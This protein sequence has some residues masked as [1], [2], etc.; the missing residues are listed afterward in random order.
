LLY[1]GPNT[2]LD[3]EIAR[4]KALMGKPEAAISLLKQRRELSPVA[5][6]RVHSALG[7][8]DGALAR[9]EEAC[10]GRDW[11]ISDLKQDCRLDGLRSDLRFRSL[12]AT[13]GI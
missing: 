7:D 3:A 5:A 13:V 12:L 9:I 8:N 4:V 2:A 11:Y 10:T 1:E 6:A